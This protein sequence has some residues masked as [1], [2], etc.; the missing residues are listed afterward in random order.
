LIYLPHSNL[1]TPTWNFSG[2]VL[3]SRRTAFADGSA[4][5]AYILLDRRPLH[6]ARKSPRRDARRLSPDCTVLPG[7]SRDIR[8]AWPSAI[9]SQSALLCSRPI[10]LSSY[11]WIRSFSGRGWVSFSPRDLARGFS[12]LYGIVIVTRIGEENR[13]GCIRFLLFD[14]GSWLVDA[15]WDLIF[16]RGWLGRARAGRGC[17]H[18]PP[19][20]TWVSK[21]SVARPRIT[22]F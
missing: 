17:P 16:R 2:R 10:V 11:L 14:C 4:S 20:Q 19:N 5:A 22:G 9:R 1:L 15:A 21:T 8:G 13:H 3:S 12:R 7:F 18:F 6:L